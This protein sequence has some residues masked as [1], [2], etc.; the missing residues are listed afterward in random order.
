[1]EIPQST[2]DQVIGAFKVGKSQAYIART[3]EIP[4]TSVNTIVKRYRDT[5]TSASRPR[6]GRPSV[7]TPT[8]TRGVLRDITNDPSR[9]WVDYGRGI[10]ISGDTVK[11][12]AE[13]DGLYKRHARSKPFLK[14]VHVNHRLKWTRDYAEKDWKTVIFTDEVS[15]EMGKMERVPMTIRRAGE[16]FKQIHLAGTF[17]QGRKSL[18]VWGAISHGHKWPLLRLNPYPT[19]LDPKATKINSTSYVNNVLMD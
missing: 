4:T 13:G 3:L 15:F 17:K 7:I 6:S 2:R 10:G 1:M 14:Q 8:T 18:M 12:I 16:E 5:G 19:H 11:K 9:P